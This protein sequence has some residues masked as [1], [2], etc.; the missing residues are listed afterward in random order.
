MRK[1]HLLAL[2]SVFFFLFPFSATGSE[3]IKKK[4]VL[5]L[6]AGQSDTPAHS[7]IVRGIKS[8]LAAGTEFQVEYFLEYLDRFRN[9]S[10][11]HYEKLVDLYRPKY[12]DTKLDLVIPFTGPALSFAADHGDE[13]FPKTPVVFSGVFD[14]ELDHLD[15]PVNYTGILAE[16]D[17]A[18]LSD[19]AGRGYLP[20]EVAADLANV[21]NAPVYGTFERLLRH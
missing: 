8:A 9:T 14:E 16:I 15:L 11:A 3:P 2:I 5:I 7:F 1:L 18:F 4:R 20:A 13:L 19:G 21:A 17:F 6:F 12:A 10:R